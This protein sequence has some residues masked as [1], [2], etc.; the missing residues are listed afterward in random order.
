MKTTNNTQQVGG[1]HYNL[2]IEPVEIISAF[3]LNWFQGEILKYA[4]RH[5]NKNKVVDL[6][7]AIH[8][9]DM[10]IDLKPNKFVRYS[11]TDVFENVLFNSYCDQFKHYY[12]EGLYCFFRALIVDIILGNY[13]AIDRWLKI[14]KQIFYDKEQENTSR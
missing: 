12:P 2:D 4:S 1:Q 5:W 8:V 3:H 7:K 9:N 14:Q 13:E 10:A 11:S 6:D